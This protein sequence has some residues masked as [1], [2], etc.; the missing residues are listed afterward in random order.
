[1]QSREALVNTA[2]ERTCAF[3]VCAFAGLPIQSSSLLRCACRDASSALLHRAAH[4]LHTRRLAADLDAQAA[5]WQLL[6][7]LYCSGDKPAGVALAGAAD[8]GGQQTLRQL[9]ADLV[10]SNRQLRRCAA[11]W[12]LQCW[13]VMIL[14]TLD[15]TCHTHVMTSC[16]HCNAWRSSA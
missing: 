13:G 7:S 9:T 4:Y 8:A 12:Q 6:Q 10:N 14:C 2:L 1:M 15:I 3:S 11:G 16:Q 5:S